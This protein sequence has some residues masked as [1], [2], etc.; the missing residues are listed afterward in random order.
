MALRDGGSGG[1]GMDFGIS[2][3]FSNLTDSDFSAAVGHVDISN[4]K[5]Q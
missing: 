4:G 3:I 2:E 5:S 1:V